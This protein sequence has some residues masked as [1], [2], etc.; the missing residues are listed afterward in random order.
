[1]TCWIYLFWL[2]I[3]CFPK[4]KRV[5]CTVHNW[6]RKRPK[7]SGVFLLPVMWLRLKKTKS[8]LFYTLLILHYNPPLFL[9]STLFLKLNSELYNSNS[10]LSFC[11]FAPIYS[12]H[13]NTEWAQNDPRETCK[14]IRMK[15]SV[16]EWS[17]AGLISITRLIEFKKGERFGPLPISQLATGIHFKRSGLSVDTKFHIWP[18]PRITDIHKQSQQRLCFIRKVSALDIAHISCYCCTQSLFSTILLYCSTLSPSHALHQQKHT[19]LGAP[20]GRFR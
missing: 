19:H 18:T 20:Q 2:Q 5:K 7:P 17:S 11:S 1:M 8:K 15:S 6:K 9:I 12:Q 16:S 10:S 4:I 14:L 3:H 13:S